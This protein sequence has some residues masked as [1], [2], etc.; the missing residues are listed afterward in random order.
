MDSPAYAA[1]CGTTDEN[2]VCKLNQGLLPNE[3]VSDIKP[4]DK[5]IF[6]QLKDK[7][8]GLLGFNPR[9]PEWLAPRGITQQQSEIPS[10]LKPNSDPE[11][12]IPDSLG[13]Q[14]AVGVY[15]NSLP[16]DVN[17]SSKD[18]SDFEKSY[19]KANFPDGVNPVT[20]QK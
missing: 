4:E 1:T 19:E 3:V 20:G 17:T 8:F 9:F 18:T 5:N 14:E 7:L 15:D 2:A 16:E 13:S 6:E 10:E 12:Q 11:K